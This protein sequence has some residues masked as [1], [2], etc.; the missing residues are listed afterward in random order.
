[1]V[2]A[3]PKAVGVLLFVASLQTMLMKAPGTELL[4][5]RLGNDCKQHPNNLRKRTRSLGSAR[6]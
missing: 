3:P 5:E 4:E 1:M 2:L 6:R